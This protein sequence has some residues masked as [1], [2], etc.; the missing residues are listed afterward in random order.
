MIVKLKNAEQPYSWLEVF[1]ESVAVGPEHTELLGARLS[2]SYPRAGVAPLASAAYSIQSEGYLQVGRRN[3]TVVVLDRRRQVDEIADE[4]N[5]SGAPGVGAV[6]YSVLT[7]PSPRTD[8]DVHAWADQ[9]GRMG[10]VGQELEDREWT[11]RL[12]WYRSGNLSIE[13]TKRFPDHQSMIDEVGNLTLRFQY[14][15]NFGVVRGAAP[16]GALDTTW[17]EDPS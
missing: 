17:T 14:D 2:S 15:R 4:P 7:P 10:Q 3:W 12:V 13:W 6:R 8:D 9:I 16:A 1:A 5:V 11:K